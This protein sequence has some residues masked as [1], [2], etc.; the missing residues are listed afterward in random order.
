L[1]VNDER[2]SQAGF[3]L[4]TPRLN[5]V[6]RAT[7]VALGVSTICLFWLLDPL[8]T[9]THDAIYHWDGSWSQL[10]VIPLLDFFLFWLL[11]ASVLLFARGRL[12]VAIWCGILALTPWIEINNWSYLSHKKIPY[13]L[14][15]LVLALGLSAFPLLM[16]LWRSK[17]EEK[18]KQVEE[19]ATCVFVF[20]AVSGILI[21]SRYGWIGWEARALNVEMPLHKAAHDS[22]VQGGRPRV[23]WLLFDELS[24][25]QV[26]ERRFPGLQLPGFDA[27][28]AQAA[29]F[30]H[31]VPAGSMTAIVVPSLLTG[32]SVDE[33]QPSIDVRRL[34]LHNPDTKAWRQLDEHDTV[35]QDA[36]NLDYDTAVA[37]WFNP[38]CRILPDVLEHCFW[39]FGS[40]ANNSMAPRASF[41]SNL[42]QPWKHFF[43]DGLGYRVASLFVDVSDL[44][45]VEAGQHISDYVALTAAADRILEDQT[46]GFALIHM[47][48]PHPNGI[49]DRKTDRFVVKDSG[50]VDNLALADQFLRH[51][52][53]KLE[54]SGQWD[55]STIVVM[56]DHSWRTTYIWKDLPEWTKEEQ[57]ASRGGQFDDRPAYIVKLAGQHDGLRIDAPFAALRTRRLFDALLEQKIRSKEELSAWAR[58][59]GH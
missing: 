6:L 47:P 40:S 51:V 39:A 31:T 57:T 56:G 23:I 48:I 28:A 16:A 17:F 13:W 42:M 14:S 24:Y 11:L 43:R 54:E 5:A 33:I 46:A 52:R 22:L 36:L 27:L 38:Y 9:S 55:T 21:L 7:S 53:T 10:F 1:L 20:S 30:T 59:S 58:Q 18:F 8:I 25:Q 50:Y 4:A 41:E 19:F 26:Y 44:S 45:E 37:G 34:S 15:F 35:F 3:I 29:V 49:Y 2:Q 32:A 12:R